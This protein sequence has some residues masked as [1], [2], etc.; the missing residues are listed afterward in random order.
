MD[1]KNFH[2]NNAAKKYFVF[3]PGLNEPPNVKVS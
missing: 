3:Y 2:L 1:F